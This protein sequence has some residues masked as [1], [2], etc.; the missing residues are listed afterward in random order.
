MLG[1][2]RNSAR[3]I[4]LPAVAGSAD[5][6][7]WRRTVGPYA[8]A[9][10]RPAPGGRWSDAGCDRQRD[11]VSC[12]S[13]SAGRRRLTIA[14]LGWTAPPRIETPGRTGTRCGASVRHVQ[15]GCK[16]S[17]KRVVEA[18]RVEWSVGGSGPSRHTD[19][20]YRSADRP[21]GRLRFSRLRPEG[22]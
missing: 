15:A 14:S 9:V 21:T 1:A 19:A 18:D 13:V 2:W 6:R 12:V 5:R 11:A 16:N 10:H 8:D 7:A 22:T 17:A 4:R 3:D 20:R